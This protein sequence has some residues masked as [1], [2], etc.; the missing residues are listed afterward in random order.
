MRRT[1][2]RVARALVVLVLAGIGFSLFVP[3]STPHR[4]LL[5]RLLFLHTAGPGVPAKAAVAQS[6]PPS[7]STFAVTRKAARADPNGTGLFVREWYVA[8]NAPPE[9]GMIVQ[10]LPDAAR[11]RAVATKVHDQVSVAPTLQGENA[12][13]P[14]PF[15]VPGVA[16]TD[17]YSF[18]LNDAVQSSKGT[19]GAAYKASVRVGRAIVTELMVTT[20]PSRDLGAI[21]RDVRDEA[22]LL[23][24]VLPGF[25]FVRTTTPVVASIVYG[26]VAAVLAALAVVLPELL[27]AWWHRRRE[28]RIE[29]E[30]RR[31]REQYLARGRRTVKRQRAPAWSQ[32]RKR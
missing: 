19:V 1:I 8:A 13:S 17:G 21:Q 25:S 9:V 27:V 6:V 18:L 4:P 11:A 5:G 12:V 23:G 16:N 14:K 24:R 22:A 26:V 7:E 2:S 30:Q 28:R 15:S 31:S 3:Q 10:L 20:V 29:R 32:P